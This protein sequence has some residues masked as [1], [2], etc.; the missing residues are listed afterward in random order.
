[1]RDYGKISPQFW[2]GKTGKSIRKQ[3]IEAQL[4]AL[5]L[6][7][8]PQANMLGLYY[9]SINQIGYETGL[10]TEGAL[11]GLRGAIEAGFCQYDED[12][13]VVWVIEMAHYQIAQSLSPNDNQCKGIQREY[14]SLVE[15]PFLPLFFDKY[16]DDFHLTQKRGATAQIEPPSNPL[17]SQ[18]QEQEQEHDQEQEKNTPPTT[19]NLN[20]SVGDKNDVGSGALLPHVAL[21]IEFRK[22]GIQ[23]Q[24]ANPK[25]LALASQGVSVETVG[26]ACQEAKT[27]KP[28]EQISVNYVIAIIERWSAEAAKIKASG[29]VPNSRD[30]PAR[31]S[32]HSGFEKLDYSEGIKDGRIA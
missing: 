10:D 4:V 15:S 27:S 30:S 14:N 24:P 6:M 17:R 1:M 12:S 8:C 13:E 21:S 22:H 2:I 11:K 23:T 32:R 26:A 29:A 25:L 16:K 19:D 20:Q 5:Y 3:G 7:T 18:E 28:G 31:T 9:T